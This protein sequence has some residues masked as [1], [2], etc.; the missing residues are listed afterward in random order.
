MSFKNKRNEDVTMNLVICFN[1]SVE[2]Y[3]SKL[4]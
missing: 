4:R 1:K 2:T 3:L